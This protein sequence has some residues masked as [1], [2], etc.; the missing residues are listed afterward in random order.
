[1]DRNFSKDISRYKKDIWKGFTT[2]ELIVILVAGIVGF[3]TTYIAVKYCGISFDNAIYPASFVGVPVIY[4]FFKKENGI[5][6]IKVLFRKRE[7]KSSAKLPNKSSEMRILELENN[8]RKRQ[9]D[10]EARKKKRRII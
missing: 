10:E 1:M 7:L 9:M 2:E 6:L 3:I 8:E 4:L 5:P